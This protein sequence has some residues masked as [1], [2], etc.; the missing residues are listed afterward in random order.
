MKR[1]ASSM[2]LAAS[3]G[4]LA[5]GAMAAEDFG[6][7]LRV[8]GFF[9]EGDS[10]FQRENENTFTLDDG[11]FRDATV[12]VTFLSGVT[13]HLEVG[14]NLDY[15]DATAVSGYRDFVDADGFSILHDSTLR[16]LPLSVDVR[17]IPAGRYG[18][19]GS[20]GQRHVRRPVFY[21]GGGVGL[22][23]FEYEEIGDFIDFDDPTLPV[24]F[25][26]FLDDGVAF[27]THA[28]AGIELPV[29][30][31]LNVL[32]EGRYTWADKEL[33]GDFDGFGDIDLGGPS[34]SAGVSWRF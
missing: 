13:N 11:D 18:V 12:G 31:T 26:R 8:G 6:V 34:I 16:S 5:P 32:F 3:L 27:Q 10:D 4:L 7:Q 33:G 19:R 15:Y 14:F 30:P 22:N 29:S 25:D 9:P 23:L 28:L 2:M 21:L 20:H 24:V 1:T 17:L